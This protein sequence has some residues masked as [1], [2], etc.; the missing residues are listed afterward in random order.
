M[1]MLF[2]FENWLRRSS[3]LSQRWMLTTLSDRSRWLKKSGQD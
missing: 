3:V 2:M 1:E